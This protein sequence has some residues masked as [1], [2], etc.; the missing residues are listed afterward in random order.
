M[1][2]RPFVLDTS[3]I[4]AVLEDEPQAQAVLRILSDATHGGAILYL[5]FMALMEVEYILLRRVQPE[6]AAAA[7]SVLDNWPATVVESNA[8]WRRHAAMVKA[9]GGL[10]LA[11]SWI[12]ALAILSDAQLVHKDPEFDRIPGLRS[13]KL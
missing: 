2:S 9:A 5:P 6:R 10:S 12:A 4:M 13:V 1:V 11:D 3:A 8:S 7:V